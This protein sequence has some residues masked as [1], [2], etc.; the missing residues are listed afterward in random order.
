MSE[1]WQS[2][3]LGELASISFECPNCKTQVVF[4]AEGEIISQ[5]ERM[6]SGC[7]KELP[8]VGTLLSLYRRFYQEG[9]SAV[10]L[11]VREQ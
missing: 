8:N 2:F 10:T 3:K 7:N 6:C 4:G 5:P 9:K 11:K 1:K